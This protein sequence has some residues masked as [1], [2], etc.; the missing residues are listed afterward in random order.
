MQRSYVIIHVGLRISGCHFAELLKV[1]LNFYFNCIANDSLAAAIDFCDRSLATAACCNS[2][3][4]RRCVV[5]AF[6]WR[7]RQTDGRTNDC[8]QTN[9]YLLQS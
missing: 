6:G 5:A 9:E 4:L 3:N 7:D 1:T 2:L 8:E